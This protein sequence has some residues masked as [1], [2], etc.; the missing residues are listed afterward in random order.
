ME[1]LSDKALMSAPIAQLVDPSRQRLAEVLVS[2]QRPLFFSVAA[3]EIATLLWM[4]RS[5]RAAGLRD[6]LR[7]TIRNPHLLRLSYVF[8]LAMIAEIAAFPAAF[9]AY[10][11]AVS[12]GLSLQSPAEWLGQAASTAIVDA[13]LAAVIFWAM[14]TLAEKTRLWYVFGV[15]VLVFFVL[16]AAFA[17]PVVLAPWLRHHQTL[18]DGPLATRL[19]AIERKAGVNVPITIE[20]INSR[21]D[22]SR[23]AGF[24]PTAR[25]VVSDTLV[26]N[27]TTGELAFVVARESA[28]IASGDIMRLELYATLWLI[29]AAALAVTVADRIGFRRDDDPLSRLAL[30]GTFLGVAI[31]LLLPVVNAYSRR[32]EARADHAALVTT[33]D[34]ASAVR[35]LVRIADVNLLP[36]C[37]P[38]TVRRYFLTYPPVGSRIAAI[39]GGGDP[40][41]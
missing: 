7:R 15:L 11:F 20:S 25:I 41:P 13:L 40:C 5:G 1:L 3:L 16:L 32:L 6:S 37:P 2:R 10:R 38:Q 33:A 22:V 23:T 17:E 30:L 29:V 34:P 28:H 39:R 24:G 27:A 12:S 8:C 9:I 31:L 36:V 18:A 21:A 14:L 19:Y 4:W 35:L 26:S